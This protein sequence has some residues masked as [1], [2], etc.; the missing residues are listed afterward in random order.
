MTKTTDFDEK[1]PYGCVLCMRTASYVFDVCIPLLLIFDSALPTQRTQSIYPTRMRLFVCGR[2]ADLFTACK[3]RARGT[4]ETI[5]YYVFQ[6]KGSW[7]S[8]YY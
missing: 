2:T 3:F 5:V 7:R 4:N 6:L 8:E 1:R